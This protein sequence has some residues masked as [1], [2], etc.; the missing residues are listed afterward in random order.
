[1]TAYYAL[2]VFLSFEVTSNIGQSHT[3]RNLETQKEEDSSEKIWNSE[4]QKNDG[5]KC[6]LQREHRRTSCSWK[7]LKRGMLWKILLDKQN[8]CLGQRGFQAENMQKTGVKYVYN[9]YRS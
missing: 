8:Q 6:R 7:T 3:P 1:M 5:R 2:N 9:F 4:L